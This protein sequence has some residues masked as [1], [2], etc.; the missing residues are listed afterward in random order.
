MRPFR[1][2][3]GARIETD[4]ATR[5]PVTLAAFRPARGARIETELSHA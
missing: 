1:P 3:R 5:Y 2:A 4:P